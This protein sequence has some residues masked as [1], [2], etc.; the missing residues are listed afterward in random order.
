MGAQFTQAR[1]LSLK[2]RK[3]QRRPL[4]FNWPR[5]ARRLKT[6]QQAVLSMTSSDRRSPGEP[7]VTVDVAPPDQ[8]Y[9]SYNPWPFHFRYQAQVELG[10]RHFQG[11]PAQPFLDAIVDVAA[12][13]DLVAGVVVVHENIRAASALAMGKGGVFD[14]APQTQR[15][16]A[17]TVGARRR[18]GVQ[19]R[20][21]EWAT[22]VLRRH[23][24]KIGGIQ[25]VREVEPAVIH[26]RE[27]F[28]YVQLTAYDDAC[29]KHAEQKRQALERLLEP[30]MA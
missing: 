10:G 6:G 19:A 12:D 13:L 2:T 25:G 8:H 24:D 16:F 22:F 27:P 18:W 26:E 5:L 7:E 20:R 21:P 23:L 14:L 29:S 1:T 28:I 4:V 11:A 30:V 9:P 17:Q 15:R 3:F